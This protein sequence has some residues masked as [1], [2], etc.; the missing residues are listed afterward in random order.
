MGKG[1]FIRFYGNREK[2][3]KQL[4]SFVKAAESTEDIG[5]VYRIL[6]YFQEE[7]YNIEEIRK[8]LDKKLN[9]IS[10]FNYN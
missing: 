5:F 8:T 4:E 1:N 9:L 7:K 6:D 2:I 10:W 3:K